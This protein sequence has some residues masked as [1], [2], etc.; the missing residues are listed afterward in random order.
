MVFDVVIIGGGIVGLATAYSLGQRLPRLRLGVLEKEAAVASHQTGHNSGV[1]HAGLYYR[2]GSLRAK[3]C[4]EG[5]RRMVAFCRQHDLPH[6]I[7]GKLIVATGEAELPALAELLK[8]GLQNGV[9]GIAEVGPDDI[10]RIEPYAAGIRALHVP[11]T[12]IVD[13]A[14]VARKL[15]E[16]AT[17][18]GTEIRTSTR[19]TALHRARGEVVLATALAARCGRAMS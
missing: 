5:A 10:R 9:P 3:A 16:L 7:C 6:E 12:G 14:A 19:V 17:T 13:Y 11:G 1:I 4:V 18:D 2:P 8:R 15:A